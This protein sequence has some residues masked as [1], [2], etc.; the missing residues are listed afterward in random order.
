[1]KNLED[2]VRCQISLLYRLKDF[3][4]H[5]IFYAELSRLVLD[6]LN[7]VHVKDDHSENKR[8]E[9]ALVVFCVQF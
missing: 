4:C 6:T 5:Y 7:I 9:M 8:Y 2:K 3:S 1:M